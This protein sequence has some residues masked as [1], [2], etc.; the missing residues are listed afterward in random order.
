MLMS[1]R[2]TY[3]PGG[4]AH[5]Q[6]VLCVCKEVIGLNQVRRFA[7]DLHVVQPDN[8]PDNVDIEPDHLS[9]WTCA[10]VYGT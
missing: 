6:I 10:A 3:S 1:W 8:V 7:E 4:D 5:K 2:R 9:G